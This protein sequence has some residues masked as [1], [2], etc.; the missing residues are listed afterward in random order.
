MKKWGVR[1]TVGSLIRLCA[2]AVKGGRLKFYCVSFVGSNPTATTA[3]SVRFRSIILVAESSSYTYL[4][5][6]PTPV[7]FW[8]GAFG[9]WYS[10]WSKKTSP[11]W[12]SRRLWQRSFKSLTRVRVPSL[13]LGNEVSEGYS[14]RSKSGV[15]SF[16]C[17]AQLVSSARPLS[18]RS[19]VRLLPQTTVL[20]FFTKIEIIWKQITDSII[21]RSI[22]HTNM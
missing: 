20:Q 10:S 12:W 19:Q 7:R 18:E 17:V 4:S 22:Y 3:F 16:V 15:S 14:S 1:G 21:C 11:M 5:K 6:R 13:E 8:Y 2:R 9:G